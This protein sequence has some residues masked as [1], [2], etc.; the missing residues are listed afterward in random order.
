MTKKQPELPFGSSILPLPSPTLSPTSSTTTSTTLS[1]SKPSTALSSPTSST[2][3]SSSS[4]INAQKVP[5]LRDQILKAA[6][7]EDTFNELHFQSDPHK[8]SENHQNNVTNETIHFDR[9]DHNANYELINT[10][11]SVKNNQLDSLDNI[12]I[13]GEFVTKKAPGSYCI[14]TIVTILP[15]VDYLSSPPI[16]RVQRVIFNSWPMIG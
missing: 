6:S 11:Q 12:P 16:T 3:L 5:F 15:Q 2:S 10:V 7:K 8:N 13:L 14:R 9:S 1:S 4:S